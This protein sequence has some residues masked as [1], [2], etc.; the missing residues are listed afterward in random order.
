MFNATGGT[1]P[2]RSGRQ[3]AAVVVAA[4]SPARP[5]VAWAVVWPA[6][7]VL[8]VLAGSLSPFS[9]DLS[10]AR[11]NGR[12][13]LLAIGWPRSPVADL[14][15]N[16]VV[17]LPIGAAACLW[18]RRR[19]G[20]LQ[21]VVLT[22]AVGGCASVLAETLQ[23]LIPVRTASWIDVRANMAGTL[24]GAVLVPGLAAGAEALR[25][26]ARTCFAGKPLAAV[27]AFAAVALLVAGLWPF[28]FVESTAELHRSLA[29]G[30]WITPATLPGDDVPAQYHQPMLPTTAFAGLFAAYGFLVALAGREGGRSRPEA[31]TT[32]LVHAV[33][34][35]LLIESVQ[36]FVV[37]R[38]FDVLDA[39]LNT[40]G[41][42]LGAYFAV[43]AVDAPTRSCWLARPS[44]LLTRWLLLPALLAQ[45]AYRVLDAAGLGDPSRAAAGTAT[46][47]WVPFSACYGHT[48]SSV[49]AEAAWL[50]GTSALLAL[51]VTVSIHRLGE[52]ARWLAGVVA[53]V[54]LA[55]ICE[56]IQYFGPAR[57]ADTTDVILAAGGALLA[58]AV[59]G[60][61]HRHPAVTAGAIASGTPAQR[62]P[63]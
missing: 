17:Y 2:G 33:I 59:C 39:L 50:C 11:A 62:T 8:L 37:S 32:A 5:W 19:V 20:L 46:V 57:L 51:T 31:T 14:V 23:T 52:R 43:W 36:V 7:V 61:L 42:G 63:A 53:A 35:S 4:R 22:L 21:A 55:A 47:L 27:A 24:L 12:W 41:A 30:R 16:V 58:A 38:S 3:A 26:A 9:F 18:L 13:G 28:D 15:T 56:V 10:A 6:T 60:R 49:V 25:A 40:F 34:L 44:V 29:A 48:V 45:V 1:A 54:G